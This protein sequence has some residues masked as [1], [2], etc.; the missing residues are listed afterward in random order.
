MSEKIAEGIETTTS[1]S[2]DNKVE[3]AVP[4]IVHQFKRPKDG[5]DYTWVPLHEDPYRRS[6]RTGWMKVATFDES[7]PPDNFTPQD[8]AR[9]SDEDH[10]P[11]LTGAQGYAQAR[12][13]KED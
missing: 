8:R 9:T 1:S 4:S 7:N 10:P 5:K 6:H 11:I 3:Q 2:S 13:S 12:E